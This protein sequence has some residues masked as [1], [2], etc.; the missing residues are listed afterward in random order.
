[1]SDK[2]RISKKMYCKSFK[3]LC[4]D[5]KRI[6]MTM[7]KLEKLDKKEKE[8]FVK[9]PKASFNFCRYAIALLVWATFILKIKWLLF[10]VFFLMIL[11][12]LFTVKWA[13]LILLYS[14]TIGRFFKSGD[15]FLSVSSMRFAH[16]LCSTLSVVCLLVL[17]F[18]NEFVGWILVGMFAILKTISAIGLCPAAK[19][20]SCATNKG[21]SCCSFLRKKK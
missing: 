12:A 21:G 3:D 6:V 5:R 15:E 14:N 11:S 13:P 8:Q 4:V 19:L 16:S 20:Y 1:M 9:V 17:Y 2:E 10:V 18:G 7:L